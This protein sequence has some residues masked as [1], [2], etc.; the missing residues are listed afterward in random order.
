MRIINLTERTICLASNIIPDIPPSSISVEAKMTKELLINKV[1][2]LVNMYED[3]VLIVVTDDEKM[4]FSNYGIIF[5]LLN[6]RDYSDLELYTP[7]MDVPPGWKIVTD[8]NYVD[9][10]T[11]VIK[12]MKYVV[13]LPSNLNTP[14]SWEDM[15]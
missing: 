10:E 14:L 5:P 8:Y 4:I 2:K 3:N 9:P 11:G 6:T 12:D 15:A 13:Q 1:S 7:G